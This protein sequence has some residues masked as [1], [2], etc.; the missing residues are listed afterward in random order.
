[1]LTIIRCIQ[2]K[3]EILKYGAPPLNFYDT[4]FKNYRNWTFFNRASRAGVGIGV[5][6]RTKKGTRSY[7]TVAGG[8]T[9]DGLNPY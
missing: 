5:V 2:I 7:S 3:K 4:S 9:V 6:F 8:G 1:M